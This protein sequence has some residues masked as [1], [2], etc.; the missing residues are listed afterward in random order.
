MTPTGIIDI[1]CNVRT[2]HEVANG[3]TGVDE[4]FMDKVRMPDEIRRGVPVEDYLKQMDR[5]GIE[6]SLLIAVRAG[7]LRMKYSHHISYETVA[8]HCER[9]PG[10]FHGLAGIDPTRIV[11]GLAELEHAVN[12]LGF[13]GAHLYPHWFSMPPDAPA[14]YPFYAKCCELDIPIMMQIGHCLDYQRDRVLPS[15]GRPSTLDR[16]AIDFPELKLIGIHLGW[17]WTEEMI[18]I[19]FKH[20]NVYMAGDAYAPKH[21]PASYVHYANTWGSH[22]VLFGTDWPVIDPERAVRE[23]D[24]LNLRPESWQA[25]MRE[26]AMRLFRLPGGDAPV[27]A[28]TAAQGTA[29]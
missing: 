5:A 27:P 21:W 8:E 12:D 11:S 26:N 24:D 13:V 4:N 19:C 16:V 28:D 1:V 23:I 3:Q 2:P 7:D 25:M 17:P 15:V 22:K 20:N 6:R 10:R 29:S 14:Y 9:H 18:A